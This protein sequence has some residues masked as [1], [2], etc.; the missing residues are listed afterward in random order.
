VSVNDDF[1]SPLWS[2]FSSDDFQ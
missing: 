2:W 1:L